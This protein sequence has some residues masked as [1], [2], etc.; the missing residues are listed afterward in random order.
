MEHTE[1][2]AHILRD[3]RHAQRSLTVV[4]LDLRNAFGSVHHD[5]IRA[6]LQ[7][8][9][10]PNSFIS[11]F[12]SVYSNSYISVAVN[13]DWSRP[14][15]VDRGV[16]QGDPSSPIIFN[17]CFNTLMTVLNRPEYNKLG[18]YSG[19]NETTVARQWLQF[20]DDACIVAS[21]VKN[22]QCLLNLFQAWCNWSGLSVRNDKCVA[23]SMIKKAS[24]YQ[25]ILPS[26]H[27]CGN[28]IPQVPIGGEF[29]YLG[30]SFSSEIKP[31]KMQTQIEEKLKHMLNVTAK[32]KISVQLK[33]RILSKYIQSQMLHDLKL[34]DFTQTWVE[35]TLDAMCIR[36]IREWLE[37]PISA[38]VSEILTLPKKQRRI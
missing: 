34:Y 37:L 1:T 2:L 7:Y 21:S 23:F 28:S 5:L 33:L 16:L 9:H 30:R 36:F 24:S 31:H 6:A 22:A 8:H 19:T 32:L 26:L 4:L 15:R 38:C 13:R 14:I 12:N 25:Q 20:A 29:C 18:Y 35:Q 10:L 17:L 11:I 3:A 27:I